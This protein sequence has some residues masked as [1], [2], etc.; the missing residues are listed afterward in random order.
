VIEVRE[1]SRSF[2]GGP[3]LALSQPIQPGGR[4]Q[5]RANVARSSALPV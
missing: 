5:V 4:P 2:F 1:Q 3:L